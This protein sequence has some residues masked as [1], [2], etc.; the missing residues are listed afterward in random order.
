[1]RVW[2]PADETDSCCVQTVHSD[3]PTTCVVSASRDSEASV[4][5]ADF[6]GRVTVWT[7]ER[8]TG[9]LHKQTSTRT[10][11]DTENEMVSKVYM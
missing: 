2:N 4:Y 5:S 1:M 3:D 7:R 9:T 8:D 10:I 6:A 11:G